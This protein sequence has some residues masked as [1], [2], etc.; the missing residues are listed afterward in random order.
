M[1]QTIQIPRSKLLSIYNDG[2]QLTKDQLKDLLGN[3]LKYSSYKDVSSHNVAC[4]ILGEE[5]SQMPDLSCR[6]IHQIEPL[7]ATLILWDLEEAI[8]LVDG[9][10]PNY[11]D[12][13]QEKWK[14]YFDGRNDF[15]FSYSSYDGWISRT[16]AGARL[17]FRNEKI[18]NFFGQQ[19]N[20]LHR[21]ILRAK[22]AHNLISK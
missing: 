2:N 21:V 18:S 8:N 15:G 16:F 6:P 4:E 7:K 5:R 14:P 22:Y 9:F 11:A 10:V 1:E 12:T 20:D 17:G 13:N 19:F 3:A